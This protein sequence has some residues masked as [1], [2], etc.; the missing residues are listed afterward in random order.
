M[1]E[2][3]LSCYCSLEG[4]VQ[5]VVNSVLP[6]STTRLDLRETKKTHA[7]ISAALNTFTHQRK[8]TQ[9]CLI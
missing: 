7:L 6:V 9:E 8:R 2:K 3:T 5:S 1:K 4:S